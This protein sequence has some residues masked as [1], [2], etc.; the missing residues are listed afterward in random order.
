[1]LH[2]SCLVFG[3]ISRGFSTLVLFIASGAVATIV[4]VF[5]YHKHKAKA[6][7]DLHQLG[8]VHEESG[9]LKP[10]PHTEGNLAYGHVQ[11][12]RRQQSSQPPTELRGQM[13]EEPENFTPDPHTQGN[14]AYLDKCSFDTCMILRC[15][16]Q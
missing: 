5:C 7:K 11:H 12:T 16:V 15:Q 2:Y 14:V 4:V 3:V 8:P 13:Y 10:D 1:M 9:D 6:P